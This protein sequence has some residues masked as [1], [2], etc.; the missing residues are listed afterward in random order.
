MTDALRVLEE[1]CLRERVRQELF[2]SG[3]HISRTVLD[4]LVLS[5]ERSSGTDREAFSELLSSVAR[6]LAHPLIRARPGLYDATAASLRRSK[7]LRRDLRATCSTRVRFETLPGRSSYSRVEL[8][9][10]LAKRF[11]PTNPSPL[12]PFRA[13]DGYVVPDHVA[14]ALVRRATVAHRAPL[15]GSLLASQEQ[16]EAFTALWSPSG[17]MGLEETLAIAQALA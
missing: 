8:V 6:A 13:G 10:Q 3:Y 1:F 7:A 17:E 15:V 14:D 5:W 16:F 11:T 4:D 12:R 2:V 9:P